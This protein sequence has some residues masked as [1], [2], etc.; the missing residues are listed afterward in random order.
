MLR[1]KQPVSI[2]SQLPRLRSFKHMPVSSD[3]VNKQVCV[4]SSK[5][6][7]LC[8]RGW[9]LPVSSEQPRAAFPPTEPLSSDIV[10]S[11]TYEDKNSLSHPLP[12]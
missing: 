4:G 9:L 7:W 3:S 11:A 10:A 2:H 1:H 8:C 6:V 5:D 12:V